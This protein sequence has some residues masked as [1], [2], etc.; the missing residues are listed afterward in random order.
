MSTALSNSPGFYQILHPFHWL[1]YGQNSAGVQAIAAITGTLAATA[2]GYFA[3]RAYFE[4]ARQVR[5]A[6]EQLRLT[7]DQWETD[8]RR[9]E[10]EREAARQSVLAAYERTKAE[11]DALRPRFNTG[12]FSRMATYNL[13]FANVGSSP[14]TEVQ[15]LTGI[16]K[17]LIRHLDIIPPNGRVNVP[18]N[19]IEMETAG[20]EIR[21]TTTFG[22]RWR[23]LQFI[24]TPQSQ[25]RERVLEVQ[26]IYAPSPRG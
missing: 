3:G 26:R 20:I 6:D 2:A 5:I 15:F 13:E 21:F 18:V 22:S 23:I 17:D 9:Y 14:A 11:E 12:G 7:K 19:I 8:K 10:L 4:T 24:T 1:T 25:V 16:T